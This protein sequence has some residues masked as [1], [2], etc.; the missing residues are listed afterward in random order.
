M[1]IH[2]V[3]EL[4]LHRRECQLLSDSYGEVPDAQAALRWN[5]WTHYTQLRQWQR[6]NAARTSDKAALE[7]ARAGTVVHM[8]FVVSLYEEQADGGR[9]F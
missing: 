8:D 7:R 3:E 5:V 2:Q 4:K 6:L 9:Y 1:A